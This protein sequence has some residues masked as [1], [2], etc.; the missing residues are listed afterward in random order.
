LFEQFKENL[1]L[2]GE[3]T[4]T[5]RAGLRSA[6]AAW[7][8]ATPEKRAVWLLVPAVIVVRA[9]AVHF[10]APWHY[11]ASAL[12]FVVLVVGLGWGMRRAMRRRL[13]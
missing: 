3:F 2:A 8:N 13:P 7:R 10:S 5:I 11:G 9:V 4:R 1:N 6:Q 12:V